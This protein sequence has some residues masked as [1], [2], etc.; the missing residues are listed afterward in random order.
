MA[1]FGF[2]AAPPADLGVHLFH[3]G[4]RPHQGRAAQRGAGPDAADPLTVEVFAHAAGLLLLAH[5][6]RIRTFGAAAA[7][8]MEAYVEDC[9]A[10]LTHR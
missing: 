7:P 6:G 10:R 3:G 9:I 1:F 8:L 5:T 4:V 2:H